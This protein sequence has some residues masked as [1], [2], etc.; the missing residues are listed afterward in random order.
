MTTKLVESHRIFSRVPFNAAVVL[1]LTHQQLDVTLLDIA[2]KGALVR[3]SAPTALLPQ[4]PC[5]LVL[6]LTDGGDAIEMTGKIVHL[7]GQ[8][9]GMM[10]EHIDLVSLTRLRRLM[11]LNTGDADLMDRELSNLFA[12]RTT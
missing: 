11:E 3:T 8:N 7:E 12:K 6:P 1:H 4:E 2:L 9:V 5:R 10:C